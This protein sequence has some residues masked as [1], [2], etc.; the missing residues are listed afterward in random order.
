L[1]E[2]VWLTAP[3]L[4]VFIF[5]YPETSADNILRRRAQRLRKLTGRTNIKSKSEIEQEKLTATEIALDAL[6]KPVEIMLKDPAVLFT[7][8]YVSLLLLHFH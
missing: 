7:N 8:V 4:V 1:W 6:I 2:I 3:I 5:A